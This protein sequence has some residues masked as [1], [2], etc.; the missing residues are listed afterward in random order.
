[1]EDHALLLMD[2]IKSS[3]D[4]TQREIKDAT[5]SS[6][7]LLADDIGFFLS[8]SCEPV[9]NDWARGPIVLSEKIGPIIPGPPTCQSLEFLG[10]FVEGERLNFI[11]SYSGG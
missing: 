1:M 9:R 5:T 8:V 10:S 7:T 4:G 2:R 6:Y 11:A 3:S